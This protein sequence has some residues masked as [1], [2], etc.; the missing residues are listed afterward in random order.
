MMPGQSR[1]SA[2]A[3]GMRSFA[4]RSAWARESWRV[5]GSDAW[6]TT[7]SSV[8]TRPSILSIR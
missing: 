7:E 3:R 6:R 2:K 5:A 1:R 8:K 4:L